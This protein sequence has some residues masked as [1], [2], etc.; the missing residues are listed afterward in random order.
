VIRSGESILDGLEHGLHRRQRRT[1]VVARPGHQ[2]A[3]GVEELLHVPRHLVEG[4][5]ELG[6]L[7]RPL[8]GSPRGEIAAGNV[9]GRVR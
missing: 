4:G 9:A 8:V 3:T 6:D 2:L 5:P 7:A 1:Q